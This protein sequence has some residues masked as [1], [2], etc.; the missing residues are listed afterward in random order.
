[1]EGVRDDAVRVPRQQEL[2]EAVVSELPPRRFH[3]PIKNLLDTAL[4]PVPVGVCQSKYRGTTKYGSDQ[5]TGG[6][7]ILYFG[8]FSVL[9]HTLI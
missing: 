3:G 4:L 7:G 1:M 8:A 2:D 9:G 6:R 5:E